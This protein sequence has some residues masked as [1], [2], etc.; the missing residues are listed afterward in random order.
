MQ[1]WDMEEVEGYVYARN[2][3]CISRETA[4]QSESLPKEVPEFWLRYV[5]T[6]CP[7]PLDQSSETSVLQT[8]RRAAWGSAIG[9]DYVPVE[10]I[11]RRIVQDKFYLSK[12]TFGLLF[13]INKNGASTGHEVDAHTLGET[14]V[15][16]DV[17]PSLRASGVLTADSPESIAETVDPFRLFSHSVQENPGRAPAGRRERRDVRPAAPWWGAV[18]QSRPR[19]AGFHER[20][21][22]VQVCSTAAGEGSS[23]SLSLIPMVLSRLQVADGFVSLSRRS[24]SRNRTTVEHL[25][26]I[27]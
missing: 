21:R 17:Y 12:K 24:T 25:I 7:H 18:E 2:G 22:R 14:N 5:E 10:N 9:R 20:K 13:Y 1:M 27:H 23:W 6:A 3:A 8:A 4:V 19:S 16:M 15:S 26:L 11:S